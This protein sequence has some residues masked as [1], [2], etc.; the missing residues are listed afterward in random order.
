MRLIRS[1]A[2]LALASLVTPLAWAGNQVSA[3]AAYQ[4]F[5]PDWDQSERAWDVTT[6]TTVSAAIDRVADGGQRTAS[7]QA[8]LDTGA[9]SVKLYSSAQS[10]AA[11]GDRTFAEAGV[12]LWDK[13][14]VAS[15]NA[16][17]SH[18]SFK[19]DYDTLLDL[20]GVGAIPSPQN[21]YP[22][23][24]NQLSFDLK[25]SWQVANPNY[26]GEGSGEEWSEPAFLTVTK[27]FTGRLWVFWNANGSTE[28][29][30]FLGE[31]GTDVPP[32]VDQ[33]IVGGLPDSRWNGSAL[34]QVEVPTNTE[35]QFS[36]GTESRSF[37]FQTNACRAEADGMHSFYLN[38][39]ASE[40]TVQSDSGYAFL[41]ET[42]PVPEPASW[43]LML[44]GLAACAAVARRR[45]G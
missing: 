41:G 23:K 33:T 40:G 45:R 21:A 12:S 10:N 25:V 30:S 20:S 7:A 29:H 14:N 16:A 42:A 32:L 36:W 24:H 8:R 5:T 31:T 17:T 11:T 15:G 44:A 37:C 39:T 19:L 35:L 38:L 3:R 43:A 34:F 9:G 18:L 26:T 13:L 6:P 27:G 1:T 22:A 28:Y 4:D 2:A